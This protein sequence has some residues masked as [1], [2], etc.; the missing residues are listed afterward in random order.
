[1]Y[2][3][4]LPLSTEKASMVVDQKPSAKQIESRRAEK[5][6]NFSTEAFLDLVQKERTKTL[7]TFAQCEAAITNERRTQTQL[8]E[9][10]GIRTFDQIQA[11]LS[12]RLA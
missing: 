6:K 8:K 11:E 1:M 5:P 4:G 7:S 10:L 3:G 2:F 12:K 9:I